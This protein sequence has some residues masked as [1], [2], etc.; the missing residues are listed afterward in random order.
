MPDAAPSPAPD[1]LIAAAWPAP[2]SI[3]ACVTTRLGPGISAPPYDRFNLG[4]HVGDQASAVSHNRARLCTA[5]RL[6][7]KP[8]WMQQVHG[9]LVSDDA[10]LGKQTLPGPPVA[11]A[12]ITRQANVVLAVLSADCLPVFLCTEDGSELALIHAGWRGLAAGVI[13][14]CV[15]RMQSEPERLLAWLGPAIGRLAF[16]VG[17]EVRDAMCQGEPAAAAAFQALNRHPGAPAKWLCDLYLLARQRLHR[18]GLRS[19]SGGEFCTY[20]DAERFYSH[21]RDGR[22]GRMASLIWREPN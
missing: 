16:E 1:W 14:T 13:E 18:L 8:L 11:D 3:H 6:P 10:S 9:V 17:A 15:G 19:V 22:S 20:R 4:E 12:A 2:A 21:R 5:L 7:A